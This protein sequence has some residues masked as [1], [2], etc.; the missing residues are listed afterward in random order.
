[1]AAVTTVGILTVSDRC[2]RGEAEDKVCA[3]Q[4]VCFG[5]CVGFCLL[6]NLSM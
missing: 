2:S 3:F 4:S 5:A 6:L 1:M